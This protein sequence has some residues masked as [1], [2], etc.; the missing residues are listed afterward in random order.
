MNDGISITGAGIVCAI[1]NDKASVLGSLRKRESGVRSVKYLETVHGD[2][3]VGEVQL[4]NDEMKEMLGLAS[5]KVVSRTSLMGALAI[6]QALSQAGIDRIG[7]KRIALIS[8]T[9][10]GVM[11]VTEMEFH[12]NRT[13]INVRDL[14]KG[15]ECGKSTAQMAALAGLEDVELCTVSTACSSALNSI[16]VGAEMLA[17]SEAD[18]VIAGG[19]EALSRF[20]LNGFNT[21][22]ILDGRQCRPFDAGRAGLNLGEGAA[23]VVLQKDAERPLAYVSGYGNRCDAFHQTASSENGEGAFLAMTQAL[24]SAALKP[25]DI[26]YINA[27]GTGTPNNDLSESRALSRVFG[28][29]M[30]PVSSTKGFT[31]HT[32][33]ASG[34]IETVI[35]L[36]AMQNDMI[37][38]NLGWTETAPGLAVPAL[39]RENVVLN[40]V[41]CNSFGF[42]GND[43]SLVLSRCSRP[44][45]VAPGNFGFELAADVT[46]DSADSLAELRNYVPPM[47]SRR[48]CT[49]LK[50]SL[51]SS[52]RA[53]EISG[54]GCPDAV[55]AATSE[56]MLETSCQFLQDLEEN[57]EAMLKPTLFMMST[58]NTVASA[59]AIRLGCHG[60]NITYSQGD[61]SSQWALRDAQRL[62]SDGRAAS[63]LVVSFDE[64]AD[65]NFRSESR[66]LVS[67]KI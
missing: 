22:M 4:S 39:G 15:N 58:H 28:E 16:I 5:D 11:D 40:H 37:P 21:L 9:T 17:H 67:K 35:C 33:S 24:E 66:I 59:I 49:L 64:A 3:P 30:P 53:V 50:A 62:V 13:L 65:G 8:G 26:D 31:G 57:A 46:V 48:M 41:M 6:R 38:A 1:G 55:V 14:P 18:I 27:H 32:T 54:I 34:A 23:F 56:G 12:R 43:S 20:H 60:Y 42:G 19:S 44:S 63:V 10:V 2:L 52:L 25:S 51:L 61:A 47:E 36:L 7:D 45:D 29:N